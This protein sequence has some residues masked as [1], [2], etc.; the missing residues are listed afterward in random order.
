MTTDKDRMRR[1]DFA[2]GI[3]LM[4]FGAWVV[5][6]TVA[7]VPMKGSWGGVMNVWYVSPGL[8]PIFIGSVLFLFGCV[9]TGIAARHLG[10]AAIREAARARVS[11]LAEIRDIP[12]P[13]FRFLAVVVILVFYI[14]LYMSRIDFFLNSTLFLAVIIPVF[15]LDEAQAQR[16]IFAFYVAGSALLIAVFALG[17]DGRIGGGLPHAPDWLALLFTAAVAACAWGQAR[18]SGERTRKLRLALSMAVAAPLLIGGMFKYFLLVPL[19]REG[20]VVAVLDA[21]YF[22]LF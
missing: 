20:L 15:Y 10:G 5:T 11:A 16:R 4:L 2:S 6:E 3:V 14:Y 7:R 1:K 8:F 13:V 18:G 12:E 22:G 17:L 9:L 19:P 21:V